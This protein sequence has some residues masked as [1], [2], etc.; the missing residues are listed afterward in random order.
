MKLINL[1]TKAVVLAGETITDFRGDTAVLEATYA[2]D[3][4][5]GKVQ[6][7]GRLYY[8]SVYGLEFVPRETSGAV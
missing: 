1:K 8:P 6:V 2:R 3:G 7:K 5:R 4:A